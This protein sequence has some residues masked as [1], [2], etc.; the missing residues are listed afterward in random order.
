MY[1]IRSY[2]VSMVTRLDWT[3]SP[4]LSLQLYAQPLL[5]SGDYVRYKQLAE[6]QTY[7]F[8]GFQPRITS[9]NVCYTKLLRA[10]PSGPSGS[11][12]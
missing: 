2:Y 6:A 9:Y 12:R 8:L 5:S 3:F 4:T 11:R 10:W 1:A 7:G